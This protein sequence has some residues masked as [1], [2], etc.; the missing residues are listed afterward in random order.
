MGRD[1]GERG[2][3]TEAVAS[4]GVGIWVRGVSM[5]EVEVEES[6]G[7]EEVR[8]HSDW[9]RDGLEVSRK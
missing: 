4:C 6:V 2:V 1:A 8:T 3:D 9:G 7:L 5:E